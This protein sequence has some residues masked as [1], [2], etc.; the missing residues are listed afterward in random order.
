M[1]ITA[2]GFRRRGYGSTVPPAISPA[3]STALLATSIGGVPA[4]FVGLYGGIDL[5]RDPF[6]DAASGG[7]R[8]TALAT[9]D[10][11]AG[12]AQQLQILTGIQ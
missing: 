6:S 12:R 8:L 3:A 2:T 7:L 4:F 5:I 11:S 10:V 1:A 9:M